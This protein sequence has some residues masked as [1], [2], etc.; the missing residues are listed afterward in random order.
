MIIGTVKGSVWAT[1]K[2]ERLNG[3]K[4]MLVQTKRNLVVAADEVGAGVGDVVLLCYGSSAHLS[5]N[6][7][8]DA[9]IVGIVDSLESEELV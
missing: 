1:K 7:P 6:A 9:A 8:I 4:L 2:D 3:C 5:K